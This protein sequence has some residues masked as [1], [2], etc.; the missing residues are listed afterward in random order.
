VKIVHVNASEGRGG[1]GRS[2]ARLCQAL[3]SIGYDS[4]LLVAERTFQYDFATKIPTRAEQDELVNIRKT[5]VEAHFVHNNR[6]KISNTHFSTYVDGADLS[7]HPSI[8][9]ADIVHLHW[10]GSFQTPYDVHL[11]SE[12]KPI[13][14]TLHDFEPFTGGC[15]FPAGCNG[16][17]TT[18]QNCPQ[19]RRDPFGVPAAVLRDKKSLWA[20]Q[21]F[22]LTS[23]SR[24]LAEQAQK[25][26]IWGCASSR[27]IVIPP[28]IDTTIFRPMSQASAR[29]ALGLSQAGRYVLCGADDNRERR[30]GSLL[31][32]RTLTRCISEMRGKGEQLSVIS[33]GQSSLQLTEPEG[34]DY[35]HLGHVAGEEM[36]ALAYAAADLFIS[37]SLEDNMPNMILESLSCGTPVVAFQVGGI[38]ELLVDGV[39][40]RL[41]GGMDENAMADAVVSLLTNPVELGII[42]EQCS[43]EIV[44]RYGYAAVSKRYVEV[45]QDLLEECARQPARM[46]LRN[47]LAGKY[48]SGPELDARL[49]ELSAGCLALE[50]KGKQESHETLL[51]VA[52]ERLKLIESLHA[53][54]EAQRR[55]M[56]ELSRTLAE[57]GSLIESLHACAEAQHREMA[58]LN[59]TLAERGSLIESLDATARAQRL[60][61]AG[62][63]KLAFQ[64]ENGED[65]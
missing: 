21:R 39:H 8:E 55:E 59:K 2:C 14:W 24:W 9:A 7:Q 34:I 57:R 26:A 65:R 12:A 6:T 17:E 52:A 23:P 58:E 18:C 16:F 53:S 1:A 63:S 22:V 10:T 64:Q 42:R 62:L 43:R 33:V 35:C 54:A 45:Y 41:I 27:P 4:K 61:I 56:A 28:T 40:G 47:R 37:S 49:L 60:Q 11:L 31:L 46:K 36:M 25:S 50:L 29:R 19:L 13:V 51:E 5:A 30:K 38:G 48:C 15:H 32:R 3:R 44:H 20:G